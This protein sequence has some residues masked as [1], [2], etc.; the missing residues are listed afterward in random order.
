M[1]GYL[2]GFPVDTL[3][4]RLAAF[5]KGL[6]AQ[7]FTEGQN[8]AIEYRSADGRMERLPGLAADLVGRRVTAI[9]ATGGDAPASEAKRASKTIPIVFV[10]GADPVQ[11]GLVASLNRPGGNVTGVSFLSGELNAKRLELLNEL[12]PST[13]K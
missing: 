5:R 4:Q 6:E 11:R 8:C 1:I 10:F 13:V 3:P 7:G 2:T 12:V 9:V